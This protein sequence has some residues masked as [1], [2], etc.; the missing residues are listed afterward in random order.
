MAT[1]IYYMSENDLAKASLYCRAAMFRTVI[2]VKFAQDN[3]SK[4]WK[5][6]NVQ[7]NCMKF[8][9]TLD[10]GLENEYS[11]HL[12]SG[13]SLPINYSTFITQKQIANGA[14]YATSITRSLSRLKSVFLTFGGTGL[15]DATQTTLP[16]PG[17]EMR[18]W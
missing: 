2:D 7:L 9:I 8:F 5:I 11:Q 17:M 6:T 1:G 18:K 12:L 14:D 10:D 3:C 4:T 13:K 16:A 15:G